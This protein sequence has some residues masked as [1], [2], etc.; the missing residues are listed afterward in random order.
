MKD[1]Q[2]GRL[3]SKSYRIGRVT[4][5]KAKMSLFIKALMA[6]ASGKRRGC[7]L[8]ASVCSHA[9]ISRT[10]CVA[11]SLGCTSGFTE[12]SVPNHVLGL[13]TSDFSKRQSKA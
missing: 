4:G 2:G 12:D 9:A 8:D 10:S 11:C 6:P 7:L 13:F 1:G 3:N 5:D